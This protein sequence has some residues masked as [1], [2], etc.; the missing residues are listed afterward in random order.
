MRCDDG[1]ADVNRQGAA[2]NFPR[3]K[4][5]YM[6]QMLMSTGKMR[7]FTPKPPS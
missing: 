6:M 2:E 5:V 7:I 4:L 3:L 1:A